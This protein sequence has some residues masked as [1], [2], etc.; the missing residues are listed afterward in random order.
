MSWQKMRLCK[1]SANQQ[2]TTRTTLEG[3]FCLPGVMTEARV[4]GSSDLD[5]GEAGDG[6]SD[7][8]MERHENGKRRT[9]NEALLTAVAPSVWRSRMEW[10]TRQHAPV[11]TQL[12]R[13]VENLRNMLEAQAA[14]QEAQW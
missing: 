9:R 5:L 7:A 6:R 13:T 11:L 10:T 2:A 4:S 14:R 12:P 8:P 1:V 3:E